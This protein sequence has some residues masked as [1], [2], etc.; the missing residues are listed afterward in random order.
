LVHFTFL[1]YLPKLFS[2]QASK[3]CNFGKVI[4]SGYT[5]HIKSVFLRS[6][7]TLISTIM[8]GSYTHRMHHPTLWPQRH[9]NCMY[10]C[11]FYR[12]Q[13]LRQVPHKRVPK[14]INPSLFIFAKL[15][16]FSLEPV[17]SLEHD[18]LV[19]PCTL[20]H[21]NAVENLHIFC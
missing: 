15:T 10:Q 3:I 7:T 12:C 6:L 8:L 20:M 5:I 16:P 13:F 18:P 14:P 19:F 9:A 11:H 4:L 21:L 1:A 2:L 17:L